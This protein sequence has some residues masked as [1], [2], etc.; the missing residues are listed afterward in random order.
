MEIFPLAH[1]LRVRLGINWVIVTLFQTSNFC[2]DVG[3]ADNGEECRNK[4][5]FNGW[6][7]DWCWTDDD[8]WKTCTPKGDKTLAIIWYSLTPAVI[9]VILLF[10]W[11]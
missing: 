10:S 1:L 9:R 7:Y 6:L 2:L 11:F 8:E 3:L 4:C 5:A